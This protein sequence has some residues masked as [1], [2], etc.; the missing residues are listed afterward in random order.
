MSDRTST[1][2]STSTSSG[3]G[4]SRTWP[5]PS[6]STPAPRPT[7]RSSCSAR[8][9]WS[10]R[11]AAGRRWSTCGRC[12][13]GWNGWRRLCARTNLRRTENA[14]LSQWWDEAYR[15]RT[16]GFDR[17]LGAV[18]G[19]PTLAELRAGGVQGIAVR[20]R[21]DDRRRRGRAP[22][23]LAAVRDEWATGAGGAR[24][25]RWSALY[26]VLFGDTE[27]VAVWATDLD[28]HVALQRAV[29][30]ADAEL[31]AWQRRRRQLCVRFRE[32]L[33]VPGAGT[34]LAADSP[35]WR[36]HELAG[37]PKTSLSRR[38]VAGRVDWA[39]QPRAPASRSSVMRPSS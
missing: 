20:A 31:V 34:P 33:L 29:D 5:T 38:R 28:S 14:E 24:P 16:G 26:E 35:S 19:C 21:A 39:S 1:S 2:T 17:L 18:P 32:E 10:G 25:S 36:T 12:V 23:Y 15:H 3:K 8:G 9:T 13:D 11:P 22:A 4:R 37:A 27:V 30:A 7:G 6:R